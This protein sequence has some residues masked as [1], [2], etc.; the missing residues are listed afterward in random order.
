MRE[1]TNVEVEDKIIEALNVVCK[2][3]MI[4]VS[5]DGDSCPGK[6]FGVTSQILVTVMGRLETLLDVIIPNNI[7]IF[8]DK[9]SNTQL[10]VKEAANKL[11]KTAKH[12]E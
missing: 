11:L 6:I 4:D 7:Y 9:K 2:T 3:L 5:I 1:I 12:G 10:S 8:H